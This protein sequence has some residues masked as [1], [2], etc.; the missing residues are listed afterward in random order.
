VH[1]FPASRCARY[2]VESF[3]ADWIL[4]SDGASPARLPGPDAAAQALLARVTGDALAMAPGAAVLKGALL[5][6]RGRR[7]L[8]VGDHGAGVTVLTVALAHRGASV[9]GDAFAVLDEFGPLALA[10][11]FCLREGAPLLLAQPDFDRLP[12]RPDGAG[13]K[14]WA[15]DPAAAGFEWQLRQ[16]PVELCVAI[17]PNHGGRS[18]LRP[19]PRYEMARRMI[20][21]TRP[22]AGGGH[23]WIRRVAALADGASCVELQLGRLDDAIDLLRAAG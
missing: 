12:S 17:Q 13:G 19:L 1:P 18:T 22:P 11:R 2:Y 6:D 5:T 3:G 15:W 9:E 21:R 4:R 7:L 14:I 16:G 23:A 8:L 10:R 20:A